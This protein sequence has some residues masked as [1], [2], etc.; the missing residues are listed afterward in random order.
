[1]YV[2]HARTYVRMYM[3]AL[4]GFQQET[5]AGMMEGAKNSKASQRKGKPVA[6]ESSGEDGALQIDVSG[7]KSGGKKPVDR[8]KKGEIKKAPGWGMGDLVWAK[9]SGF[10]HWPA[11][12]SYF[13]WHCVEMV[14]CHCFL[15]LTLQDCPF[16][17]F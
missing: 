2:H 6:E 8:A 3:C 17:H 14:F 16:P 12:V 13:P 4:R 5:R 15:L 10:V 1:M 7:K 11:K 9:V